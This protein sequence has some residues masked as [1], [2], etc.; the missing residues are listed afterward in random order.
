MFLLLARPTRA[1]HTSEAT[2]LLPT[3]TRRR[4]GEQPSAAIDGLLAFWDEVNREDIAIVERVQ[5]GLD[6]PAV[7]GRP[8]V[9]PLRGAGAPLPEH[10][11]RP[12][13]RHSSH[14]TR[15]RRG[16]ERRCSPRAACPRLRRDAGVAADRDAELVPL[17]G[18]R[19]AVS[20]SGDVRT[21]ASQ[22]PS[23]PSRHSANASSRRLKP[24][25]LECFGWSVEIGSGHLD[26]PRPTVG[27]PD[28]HLQQLSIARGRFAAEPYLPE[29]NRD[30]LTRGEYTYSLSC[31]Q[32]CCFCD[33]MSIATSR[34]GRRRLL[35]PIPIWLS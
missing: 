4:A 33:R 7:H 21:D 15:R 8:H 1:G 2:Y 22:P 34:A 35:A 32:L 19:R 20:S 10:G 12:H 26:D 18:G 27:P 23:R 11:H 3:P 30:V 24:R 5:A 25:L 17:C 6:D 13:A 9:L 28:E 14:P 16:A 29:S 31:A